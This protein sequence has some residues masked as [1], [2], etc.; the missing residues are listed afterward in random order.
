VKE[1]PRSAEELRVGTS[2]TGF[3]WWVL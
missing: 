3:P 2:V 1:E